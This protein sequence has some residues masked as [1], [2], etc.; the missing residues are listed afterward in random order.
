[1]LQ[2]TPEWFAVIAA[3]FLATG[4]AH[5]V[6]WQC[7]PHYVSTSALHDETGVPGI[8]TYPFYNRTREDVINNNLP[9]GGDDELVLSLKHSRR[10][11]KG[12]RWGYAPH[13]EFRGQRALTYRGKPCFQYKGNEPVTYEYDA[14]MSHIKATVLQRYSGLTEKEI[15]EVRYLE[16]PH[17]PRVLFPINTYHMSCHVKVNYPVTL[18]ECEVIANE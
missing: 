5:A 6:E 12:F 17:G 18:G 7:G 1:M 13:P 4:T 15:D 8:L 9:S 3:L 10:D 16:T 2:R 14:L 11:R